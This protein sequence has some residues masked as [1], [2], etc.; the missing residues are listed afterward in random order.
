M[1]VRSLR[2]INMK[3]FRLNLLLHKLFNKQKGDYNAKRIKH[4][5]SKQN[6]AKQNV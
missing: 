2:I 1:D 5:F 4:Q 6:K 3:N